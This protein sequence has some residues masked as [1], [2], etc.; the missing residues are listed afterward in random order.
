MTTITTDNSN[1]QKIL[2]GNEV[3]ENSISRSIIRND[4]FANLRIKYQIHWYRKK[5]LSKAMNKLILTDWRTAS[6][7]KVRELSKAFDKHILQARLVFSVN[8]TGIPSNETFSIW[9]AEQG[10][11]I[12]PGQKS[13]KSGA[14]T[15]WLSGD[16]MF[17]NVLTE[18]SPWGLLDSLFLLPEEID[19]KSPHY[20][21][22]F[23]F[24][25][26]SSL[27]R[28]TLQYLTT[29]FGATF[30]SAVTKETSYLVVPYG[31]ATEETTK[32]KKIK[33]RNANL[34]P[35]QQTKIIEEEDFINLLPTLD[36]SI[37]LTQ[38]L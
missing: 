21:K 38:Y 26:K 36:D 18:S 28:E 8:R 15:S 5:L 4:A 25:G 32:L 13:Y 27:K 23:C 19:E 14:G 1:N 6:L 3:Y 22:K 33:E 7:P 10:E 29:I 11:L 12:L 30:Q 34:P 16:H 37:D 9:N 17:R 31:G 24:T 20:G 35:S 2:P